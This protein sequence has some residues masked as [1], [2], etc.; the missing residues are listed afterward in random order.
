MS[1]PHLGDTVGHVD[2]LDTI[3]TIEVLAFH[4]D[5]VDQNGTERKCMM[6]KK[7]LIED[8]V[9]SQ[10]LV[11]LLTEAPVI[12]LEGSAYWLVPTNPFT[13]RGDRM[14]ND[15]ILGQSNRRA[16]EEERGEDGWM[17]EARGKRAIQMAGSCWEAG[18]CVTPEDQAL[19]TR[20]SQGHWGFPNGIAGWSIGGPALKS[21]DP[22]RATR[23]APWRHM[24]AQ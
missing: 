21:G 6:L 5:D 4:H 8:I 2:L 3:I 15:R 11:G 23:L 16:P 14:Q 22:W 20:E 24:T 7:K 12:G 18:R 9:W 17:Q 19:A 1:L 13:M 10:F